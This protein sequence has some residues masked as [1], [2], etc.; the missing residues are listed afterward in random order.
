MI[1]QQFA[2]QGED[3]NRYTYGYIGKT[4]KRLGGACLLAKKLWLAA[5]HRPAGDVLAYVSKMNGNGGGDAGMTDGVR[6]D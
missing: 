6:Y 1:D 4:A 3:L 5:P 2:Y